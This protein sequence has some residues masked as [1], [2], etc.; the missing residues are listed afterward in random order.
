[1]VREYCE[2]TCR[3]WGS[4]RRGMNTARIAE[5]LGRNTAEGLTLRI[6]SI[7]SDC[8]LLGSIED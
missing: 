3:N 1:M 4:E 7:T 6:D 5:A 2:E 8:P